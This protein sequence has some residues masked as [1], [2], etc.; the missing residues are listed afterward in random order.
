[1]G[2][3]VCLRCKGKTLLGVQQCFAFTP[4]A[5]FEFSLKVKVM[6][7]NLGY[8]SIFFYFQ[9]KFT[10]KNN[11]DKFIDAKRLYVILGFPLIQETFEKKMFTLKYVL[12]AQWCFFF[13]LVS[14][15]VMSNSVKDQVPEV[16]KLTLETLI[17]ILSIFCQKK[18]LWMFWVLTKLNQ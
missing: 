15:L 5:N 17:G 3:K 4:Q 6:G 7:S 2:G 13:N 10:F 12:Y 14:I 8:L 16:K 1:M 9:K 18:I 11:F